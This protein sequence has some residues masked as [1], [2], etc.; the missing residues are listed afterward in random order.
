[1]LALSQK[2]SDQIRHTFARGIHGNVLLSHFFARE[3]SWY[4]IGV[5]KINTNLLFESRNF[6]M[7]HVEN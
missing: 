3:I 1:M 7:L 6:T 4:F 5:L 2:N